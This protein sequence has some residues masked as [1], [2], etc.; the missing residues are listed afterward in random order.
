[1]KRKRIAALMAGVD[2]EYQQGFTWGM[3]SASQENDVD[4]CIFNCQGHAD[5]FERNDIGERA[6]FN[7][8]HLQDFDGVVLLLETIPTEECARQIL[9]MLSRVPDMPLV[10]VDSQWGQSVSIT[11]DDSSSLRELMR[12]LLENHG[13]RE[14]AMVTGPV[15]VS[16]A[17][18]RARVAREVIEEYGANLPP[19]AVF[20]GHWVREGGRMAA[21]KLLARGKP[22]PQVIVCG[23]DDMAFGVVER[24]RENGVRIPEDVTVT[25]FD[26]R[27][28]GVGR[29]LTT[30]HRPVQEAGKC[31]VS[32]LVDWI[33]NGKPAR[34]AYK[35]P[36]NIIYGNSCGCHFSSTQATQYVRLLSTELREAEQTLLKG[37]GF[38]SGISG[39]MDV[40]SVGDRIEE[41]ARNWKAKQMHVCVDPDFLSAQAGREDHFPE[42]M[43]LLC[44]WGSGRRYP[45]QRFAT[46]RLLPLLEQER[47]KPVALVFCP[48]YSGDRGFGYA[49][50]DMAHAAGYALYAL[51]TL[52]ASALS[53]MSLH[54]TVRSYAEALED[55]S[56]HDVL[57]GLY[58][59]RGF[60]RVVMPVFRQAVREQRCFAI[61]SLDAN[62][63]KYI[64]DTF[65]HH[66]GDAAICRMSCVTKCLEKYGMTCVHVSG[67]EFL[68][69]GI[70]E[71][72]AEAVERRN[73][74]EKE[75]ERFNREDPWCCD[76]E[77]GVGVY[78]AIP[79]TP[80]DVGDFMR[81]ADHQMYINKEWKKSQH[82]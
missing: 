39:M 14:F 82:K 72:E 52:L 68:V 57:T 78:A 48:L 12:H 69:A 55:M 71:D 2:Q 44:S 36:T 53:S 73:E 33:R 67:D 60:E 43:L 37:A 21:D 3:Y 42:E 65:G 80:D 25:G 19:D 46:R 8:P 5:G 64:N 76:I 59:R 56:I 24:L 79:Q 31:A 45:Q 62:N 74:L 38:F 18:H 4:L 16:V 28:E 66:M 13:M 11:F 29:G 41:F 6:I 27:N 9:Q 23:N 70:V 75:M 20:D 61:I 1:M 22:L 58:N 7:L 77:A 15:G 32:V 63:M 17:D 81:L 26:A 30:I 50:F 40:A 34:P 54:A 10:T 47:D 49:V 51:L 35:L